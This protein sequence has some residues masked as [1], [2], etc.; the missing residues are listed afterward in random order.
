MSRSFMTVIVFF[1]AIAWSAPAI[2]EEIYVEG[3]KA[4][5][6]SGPAT[7]YEVLWE[8]PK[9]TPLEYLAKYKDWYVVRDR[10]G[11]VAWVS[12]QVI[13]KGKAAIVTN[14]KANIRKGPGTNNPIAFSVEEGYV[15]RVLKKKG[16][17]YNV[18]DVEGDEGWVIKDLVWV[19]R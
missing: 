7:K 6:R 18:K 17:W 1:L 4:R 10:E 11:D 13:G 12:N 9:Y 16:D 8:A 5:M 15:F 3:S 2:A 19:S 14:T